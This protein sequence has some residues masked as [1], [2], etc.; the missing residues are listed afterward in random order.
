MKITFLLIGLQALMGCGFFRN[1]V[2]DYEEL[3]NY[4]PTTTA[5]IL[6][7]KTCDD[8]DLRIILTE[9]ESGENRGATKDAELPEG[10]FDS[11]KKS[12]K[13]RGSKGV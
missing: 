8:L 6:C 4:T 7:K 10:R 3:F 2:R 5:G 12:G 13:S 1:K 9:D 11:H